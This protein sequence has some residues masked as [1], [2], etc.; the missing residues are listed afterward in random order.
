MAAPIK[1]MATKSLLLGIQVG[2]C[3]TPM[4]SSR[5]VECIYVLKGDKGAPLAFMAYLIN[6]MAD[7]VTYILKNTYM[8]RVVWYTKPKLS[9]SSINTIEGERL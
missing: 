2:V 1:K 7:S 8:P 5:R 9:K 4:E 6:K 3:D